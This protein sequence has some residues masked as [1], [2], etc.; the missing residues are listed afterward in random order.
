MYLHRSIVEKIAAGY[1][2]PHQRH[3]LRCHGDDA[4]QP[5]VRYKS[6]TFQILIQHLCNSHLVV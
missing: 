1:L 6:T 4:P 2:Y 3:A 5:L